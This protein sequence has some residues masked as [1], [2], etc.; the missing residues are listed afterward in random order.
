M[1]FTRARW[2]L[3]ANEPVR[4][5][6]S[7]LSVIGHPAAAETGAI[8]I[9]EIALGNKR[10]SALGVRF[11]HLSSLFFSYLSVALALNPAA[12]V[13]DANR[14]DCE[15]A[16]PVP[17]PHLDLAEVG[18]GGGEGRKNKSVV[19]SLR[20]LLSRSRSVASPSLFLSLSLSCCVARLVVMRRERTILSP[21][22]L[23]L[24]LSLSLPRSVHHH[25]DV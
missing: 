2:L 23:H 15:G 18:A 20:T 13:R 9:G 22:L 24:P 16:M 12:G 11:P 6:A 21:L 8:A 25:L 10:D 17:Q 4:H 1:R 5:F 7:A 14:L 3:P 19:M